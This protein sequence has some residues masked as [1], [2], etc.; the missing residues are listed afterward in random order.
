[1]RAK[2]KDASIKG[3]PLYSIGDLASEFDISTRTIRFYEAKGLIGPERAGT[4]RVF[5]RRD[6]ARLLLILRGKRLGFSLNAIKEYLDLYDAD[7]DQMAQ[8]RLLL[9]KVEAAISDLEAKRRDIDTTL[10][11]LVEIRTQCQ[12]QIKAAK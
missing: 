6:H 10:A 11:E 8:T 1:M 2:P 9:T 7:P 5:T 3:D 4:N 12:T